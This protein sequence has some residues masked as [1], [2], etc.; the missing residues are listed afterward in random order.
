MSAGFLQEAGAAYLAWSPETW[1]GDH[2]DVRCRILEEVRELSGRVLDIGCNKG[3]FL[4]Q[5]AKADVHG[6]DI[7]RS[8][9][10][11]ARRRLPCADIRLG[12][13]YDLPWP[14]GYF[15]AVILCHILEIPEGHQRR[16]DLLHESARVLRTGG[17][18][19]LTT[20]NKDHIR[21]RRWLD[22][23]NG[24]TYSQ[25]QGLLR[26]CGFEGEVL[27]WN[28]I[29]SLVH[30]LPMGLL[31]RVPGDLWRFLYPPSKLVSRLPGMYDR[32][33]A[34]SD[35]GG[36]SAHFKALWGVTTRV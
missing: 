24:V 11:T 17:L 30:F 18:L 34:A 13:F 19:L 27:L 31:Q 29:P 6:I 7:D 5:A 22:A 12:S 23:E 10:E 36:E 33:K 26:I 3:F 9:V 32:L 1:W 15:D 28:S 21:Y 20:P 2:A 16:C 14:D 8:F 4:S 25:L 35:T